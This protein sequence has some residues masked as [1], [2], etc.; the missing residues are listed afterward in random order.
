MVNSLDVFETVIPPQNYVFMLY[1][2]NVIAVFY[3][4]FRDI[5]LPSGRNCE[6]LEGRNDHIYISITHET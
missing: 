3:L 1:Q 6:H 2:H 4:N 5:H